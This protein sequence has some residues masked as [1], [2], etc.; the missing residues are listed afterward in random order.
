M[1]SEFLKIVEQTNLV[2]AIDFDGVLHDDDKGFHDGTIYGNLIPGTKNALKLLS[3]T[4]KLILYTCKANPLRPLVDNKNGIE[5]IWQWLKQH[6]LD[7]FISDI[8]FGKPNAF[9]YIDDKGYKFN[10]WEQT[11]MDIGQI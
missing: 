5:L 3:K 7:E 11:L 10:N 6:E 8:T 1:K 9:I 2:I 4:Y